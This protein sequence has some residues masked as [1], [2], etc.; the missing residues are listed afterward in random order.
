MGRLRC[1]DSVGRTEVFSSAWSIAMVDWRPVNVRRVM[2][3]FSE[4]RCYSRDAALSPQDRHMA[5]G[6]WSQ[7]ITAAAKKQEAS[8][9]EGCFIRALRSTLNM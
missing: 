5:P 2:Q 8:P 3:G 6:I 4:G 1:A 9:R 7:A